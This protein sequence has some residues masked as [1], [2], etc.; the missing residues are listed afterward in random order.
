MTF[1]H[2]TPT[3]NQTSHYPITLANLLFTEIQVMSYNK[4]ITFFS[5]TNFFDSTQT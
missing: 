4:I 1:S 3:Q 2:L 5:I